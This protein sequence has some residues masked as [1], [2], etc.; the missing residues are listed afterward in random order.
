MRGIRKPAK[1]MY[2]TAL[3]APITKKPL[4]GGKEEGKK[5]FL[6]EGEETLKQETLLDFFYVQK[7]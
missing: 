2:S 3:P 6:R 1:R 4:K 5:E 7:F